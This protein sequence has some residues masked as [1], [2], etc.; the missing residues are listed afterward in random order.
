MANVWFVGDGHFGHKNI[1]NFRP[2]FETVKEHDDTIIDALN[3]VCTKRDKIFFLGD[4]VFDKS[5][6][7]LIKRIRCPHKHLVLG[8]HDDYT[9]LPDMLEVFDHISGDIKYK[10][11]WLSH[12][13]IHSEELRGKCN[14]YA[15]THYAKVEDESRYFCTSLEQTGFKPVCLAE[16]RQHFEYQ[17][18]LEERRKLNKRFMEI[19]DAE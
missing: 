9:I 12:I 6:L 10:E 14:I 13:P 5:A 19:W 1:L 16:I 18:K 3:T 8:N 4:W 2:Q 11:F 15:H 17:K 7:E